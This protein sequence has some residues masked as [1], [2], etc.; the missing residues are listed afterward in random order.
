MVKIALRVV[1][2]ALAW[3][4]LPVTIPHYPA[5][6]QPNHRRNC[7]FEC[8]SQTLNQNV[9]DNITLTGW[10]FVAIVDSFSAP[11]LDN[12]L[13]GLA[14]PTGQY[15]ELKFDV[16]PSN[17]LSGKHVAVMGSMIGS[18][19]LHVEKVQVLVDF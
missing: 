12:Y 13:Y 2:I 15:L 17:E 5:G 16:P 9:Q 8:V 11:K 18:S 1:A 10:F 7:N 19:T 14:L 4:V 3:V 6:Q